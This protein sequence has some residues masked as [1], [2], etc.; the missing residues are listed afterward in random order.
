MLVSPKYE[1]TLQLMIQSEAAAAAAA[2]LDLPGCC[3]LAEVLEIFFG[4]IVEVGALVGSVASSSMDEISS[5][6]TEEAR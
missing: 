1:L 6:R 3:L 5:K 2:D 4:G